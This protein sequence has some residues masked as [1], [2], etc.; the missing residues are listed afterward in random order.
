MPICSISSAA[1]AA[2]AFSFTVAGDELALPCARAR[3][4]CG[5]GVGFSIY[6][7]IKPGAAARYARL[8]PERQRMP[9]RT[10]Q[11]AAVVFSSVGSA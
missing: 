9:T 1:A 10:R 5:N 11:R 8:N 6:P 3:D 2:R 4:T 7:S